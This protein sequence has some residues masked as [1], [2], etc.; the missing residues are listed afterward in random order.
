MNIKIEKAG[1]KIFVY[2][3]IFLCSTVSMY[4]QQAKELASELKNPHSE[5]VL[6]VA[7][8]GDWR[9]APEN[10]LQAFANCIDMGVDMIEIDLKK[11]K[12]NQLILMHD[13]TIDR[14]TNGK[15]KASGYTLEEIRKF[16]LK[17]AEGAVTTHRIPTLE[18][19]LNLTKGKILINVDKGYD[20]FKDVYQLLVKTNTIDQVVIKSGYGLEKVKTDNGDVLEKVIYMPI[21]NLDN[22]AEAEKMIDEYATI[23]P[24]AFE[25]CFSKE[26]P[27]VLRLLRKIQQNGSKIWINTMW[28]SLCA[29]HDDIRSVE[30]NQA[31]D[32]WGWVLEQGASLIQTDRPK[33]L[34]KYIE[35]KNRH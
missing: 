2:A 3:V 12:D 6:V 34:I 28:A 8:R 13:N 35:S 9:G 10:S 18:E 29:G 24:V 32:T 15:G 4:A 26:T 33:A 1:M 20:Y 31:D 27:D 14:T 23:S 5:K 7:H 19:V 11:T 21:I 25:C 22:V 16:Y 17:D 30:Q